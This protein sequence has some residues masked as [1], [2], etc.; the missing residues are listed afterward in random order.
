MATIGSVWSRDRWIGIKL[1][2]PVRTIGLNLRP[3]KLHTRL[4]IG[5][6]ALFAAIR[7]L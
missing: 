5:C 7:P 2:R 3:L 1:G 6:A 4:A